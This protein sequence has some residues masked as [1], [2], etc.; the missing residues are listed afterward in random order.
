MISRLD[1][2]KYSEILAKSRRIWMNIGQISIDPAIFID[3]WQDFGQNSAKLWP[4]VANLKQTNM[5]PKP[6]R[7]DLA[8]PKLHMG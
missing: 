3:N 1:L 6:T 4:L 2:D 8:N 5:H 7:P